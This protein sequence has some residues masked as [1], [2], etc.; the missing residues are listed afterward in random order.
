MT[1]KF[2]VKK[3]ILGEKVK[4]RVVTVLKKSGNGAKVFSTFRMAQ[5]FWAKKK[6]FGRKSTSPS[7]NGA[8][9]SLVTV[10]KFFRRFG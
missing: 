7:G 4:V 5:K 6:I 8:K 9:K 10:L 1:Q 2:L 3:K